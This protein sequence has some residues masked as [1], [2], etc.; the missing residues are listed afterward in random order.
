MAHRRAIRP[1]HLLA[2]GVQ[3]LLRLEALRIQPRLG[4]YN[5]GEHLVLLERAARRQLT[6]EPGRLHPREHRA[7]Q[8]VQDDAPEAVGQEERLLGAHAVWRALSRR[9]RAAEPGRDHPLQPAEHGSLVVVST[10]GGRELGIA[11]QREH[12]RYHRTG[13]V[14]CD[15]ERAVVCR[16]SAWW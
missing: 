12:G 10:R 7:R 2:G 4:R 15:A 13:R 8:R 6:P 11:Q 14:H 16:P 3:E 5:R 9:Q 1:A